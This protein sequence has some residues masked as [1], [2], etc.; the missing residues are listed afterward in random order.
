MCGGDCGRAQTSF[1][2]KEDDEW[3]E[4]I[5]VSSGVF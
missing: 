3:I 2:K 1:Y 4:W 5:I